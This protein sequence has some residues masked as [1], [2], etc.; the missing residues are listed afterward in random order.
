VA[1][2]GDYL[3]EED[4]ERYVDRSLKPGQVLYLFCEFTHPPKDK[5]VLLV[6][7]TDP[8][9]LFI[10][11]SEIPRFVQ[12]RPELLASQVKLSPGDYPF[13]DHDLFLDCS[14]VINSLDEDAIR[15]QLLADLSRLKGE[16]HQRTKAQIIEAVRRSRT[17]SEADRELIVHSL[18]GK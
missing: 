13:L 5:Y 7:R 11:N 2:L 14:N 3:P 4:R 18:G 17:V 10:V 6:C 15:N 1:R 12:A 8:P 9:M 16:L